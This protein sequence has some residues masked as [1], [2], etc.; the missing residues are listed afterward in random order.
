MPVTVHARR[1]YSPH[2]RPAMPVFTIEQHC[3]LLYTA[4]NQE[5]AECGERV[6]LE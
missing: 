1:M 6:I 5:E 2:V 3:R 4:Q